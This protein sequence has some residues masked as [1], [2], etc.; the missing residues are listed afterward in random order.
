MGV[1][2]GNQKIP[3]FGE[4]FKETVWVKYPGPGVGPRGR[5]PQEASS[6]IHCL[7]ACTS[8]EKAT[9]P[10][11]EAREPQGWTQE[12]QLWSWLWLGY[13]LT[14]WVTECLET[15]YKKKKGWPK[16]LCVGND[17]DQLLLEGRCI[18]CS[19][20]WWAQHWS[21]KAGIRSKL[22][23]WIIGMTLCLKVGAEGIFV[24]SGKQYGTQLMPMICLLC[25][26]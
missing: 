5:T 24:P 7:Q 1:H 17:C 4:C 6:L 19:K 21:V 10:A 2:E 8:W 12:Q 15:D 23:T 14:L 16:Q 9:G 22:G 11:W 3:G 20:T 13:K 25:D 18:D 26:L